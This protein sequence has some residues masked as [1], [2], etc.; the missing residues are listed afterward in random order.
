MNIQSITNCS[1][2]GSPNSRDKIRCTNCEATLAHPTSA[3]TAEAKG[4]S[5]ERVVSLQEKFEKY[6]ANEQERVDSL[7]A[8]ESYG[9]AEYHKGKQHAYALAALEVKRLLQANTKISDP[10]KPTI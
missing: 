6:C 7:V 5:L 2:C 1:T 10:E 8:V 9:D 3:A 4:G